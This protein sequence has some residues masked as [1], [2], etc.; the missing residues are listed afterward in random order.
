MSFNCLPPMIHIIYF[1][2]HWI[3][4]FFSIVKNTDSQEVSTEDADQDDTGSHW[5][6]EIK[7]RGLR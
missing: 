3:F 1:G 5:K 4:F 6:P 7:N 2:N